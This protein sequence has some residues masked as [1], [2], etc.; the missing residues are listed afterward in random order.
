M[1]KISRDQIRQ[2]AQSGLKREWIGPVYCEQSI[3]PHVLFTSCSHSTR[4][5]LWLCSLDAEEVMR[6]GDTRFLAWTPCCFTASNTHI[7]AQVKFK[8]CSPVGGKKNKTK[9]WEKQI[10]LWLFPL[11]FVTY[12]SL[13]TYLWTSAELEFCVPT[14]CLWLFI[15][16]IVGS[17]SVL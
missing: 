13:R 9:H 6:L 14:K 4:V 15:L 7:N 11:T 2:R 16:D 17:T 10:F 12:S 5:C 8:R 1:C 3:S